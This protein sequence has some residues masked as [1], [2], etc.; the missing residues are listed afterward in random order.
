MAKNLGGISDNMRIGV[1]VAAAL[2]MLLLTAAA[3][4]WRFVIALLVS[5]IIGIIV[6]LLLGLGGEDADAGARAG[7]AAPSPSPEKAAPSAAV[8]EPAPDPVSSA[9]PAPKAAEAPVAETATAE[10]PEGKNEPAAEPSPADAPAESTVAS[11]SA[12]ADAGSGEPL[13][14]PSTPLPGQAELAERKGS[15]RYEPDTPAKAT[16]A[17]PAATEAPTEPAGATAPGGTDMGDAPNEP[18][19]APSDASGGDDAQ[20]GEVEPSLYT[21]APEDRD[22][23][24]EIKG[25]GPGLEN[26]LNE[27]GIYKFA[28]IASWGPAEVAW[29]DARLKFKGRITR[30][31]WI[32]QATALSAGEKTDFAKRVDEGGVY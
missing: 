5:V 32:G 9:A 19:S 28:Q 15:W 8:A 18:K 2:V 22:N 17:A 7:M 4:D 27:L 21:S 10:A 20:M 14:K 6:Y 1:S 13:I 30:D 11:K 23:L 31:D 3:F 12:A 26:T 29:V 16:T 24:K 25:V